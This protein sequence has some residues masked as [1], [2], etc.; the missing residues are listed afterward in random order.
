MFILKN[1]KGKL[2]YGDSGIYLNSYIIS[3]FIIKSYNSINILSTELIMIILFLPALDL[4]R[5]FT[6]RLIL[7]KNPFEGD[8]NHIHHILLN[9]FDNINLKVNLVLILLFLFPYIFYEFLN[10]SFI[11]SFLPSLIFYFS[12]VI[13]FYRYKKRI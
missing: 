12:L 9:L 11:F 3:Y 7:L 1:F 8:R 6:V 4:L 13:Y 10:I 5:V 2:F